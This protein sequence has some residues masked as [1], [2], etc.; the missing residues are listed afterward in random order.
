[1]LLLLLPPVLVNLA[2]GLLEIATTK[3]AG[4]LAAHW[5]LLFRH[6]FHATRRLLSGRNTDKL[7]LQILGCLQQRTLLLLLLIVAG[8][9]EA[10]S[11]LG[12]R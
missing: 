10:G 6:P 1:M 11:I 8:R 3:E 5:T 2:R 7:L 12:R 4:G 9:Q